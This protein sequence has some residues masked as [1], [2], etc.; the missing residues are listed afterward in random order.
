MKT[1]WR[2]NGLRLFTNMLA[3]IQCQ[4]KHGRWQ[5]A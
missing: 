2:Q 5:N 1:K 3:T 4:T